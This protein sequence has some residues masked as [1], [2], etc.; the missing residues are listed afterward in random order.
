MAKARITVIRRSFHK[1]LT[2]LYL[3]TTFS[4][5]GLAPCESFHDGQSFVIEGFPAKPE[6]FPCEWAWAD[7]HRAIAM[8]LFGGGAPWIKQSG[9]IVTCCTDGLR[10][11]TFLVERIEN[12]RKTTAQQ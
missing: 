10:P 7:L 2:A 8:V 4:P 6:G 9:S 11:V 12:K 1:D 5:Q 3:D